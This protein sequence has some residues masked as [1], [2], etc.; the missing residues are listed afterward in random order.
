LS[1]R[2]FQADPL[3]GPSRRLLAI[4]V[5]AGVVCAAGCG[6]AGDAKNKVVSAA[7]TTLSQNAASSLTIHGGALFAGAPTK[8]AFARAGSLFPRALGYEAIDVPDLEHQQGGRV[9]LVFLPAAVYISP[10]SEARAVLPS[11]KSWVSVPINPSVDV[12]FPHSVEQLEGLNPQLLLDEIAWGTVRASAA[13]QVV[14]NHIPYQK[15]GVLVSLPRALAGAKGPGKQAMRLALQ[16]Q[17]AALRSSRP[18][19]PATVPIT[20]W[21]DGPGHLAQ[22]RGVVPGSGLGTVGITLSGFGAPIR[23]TMPAAASLV[24]VTDLPRPASGVR[25]RSPLVALAVAP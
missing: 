9:Y 2:L 14:V 1:G 12:V 3:R 21:L 11:G 6:G 24:P 4:V 15:Y 16:I 13:G 19:D 18:S 20:V 17:I 25:S 22:L 7:T 10:S 23:P 8:T 5:A